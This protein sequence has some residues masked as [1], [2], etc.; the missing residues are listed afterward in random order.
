MASVGVASVD[1]ISQ[2]LR[3]LVSGKC[4]MCPCWDWFKDFPSIR[5]SI[6]KIRRSQLFFFFFSKLL[7]F[8]KIME[9]SFCT[10]GCVSESQLLQN[11]WNKVS[12]YVGRNHRCNI[13][14]HWPRPC[15][16]KDRK[17][18]LGP[19]PLTIF[20]LN[21][22]FDQN[23]QCSGLK[24]TPPIIIK[25]CTH[26]GSITVVTCA[27]FQCDPLSILQSRA[28]QVLIEFRIQSNYH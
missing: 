26:H 28:L 27:K 9:R 10:N 6:I 15:L 19:V 12:G 4:V 7:L 22:K 1:I 18:V 13:F 25:F 24:Y 17:Q 11:K 20:L 16:A 23:L 21:S 14:S 3:G 5:I 8:I 2:Y